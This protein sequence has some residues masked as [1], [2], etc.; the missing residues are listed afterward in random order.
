MN[1]LEVRGLS[2]SFRQDGAEPVGGAR[3]VV[4]RRQGRNR[5]AGGRI[6]FGQVGRALSTVGLLP[7]SGAGSPAR[8]S[9]AGRR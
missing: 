7:E 8:S 1:L 6:R 9:I 4:P 3:R 5:G 2:V